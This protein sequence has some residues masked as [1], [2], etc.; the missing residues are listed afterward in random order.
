VT[1]AEALYDDEMLGAAKRGLYDWVI[2]KERI[3]PSGFSWR[4]LATVDVTM[5]VIGAIAIAQR[6]ISDWPAASVALAVA[7]TPWILFFGFNICKHE[8]PALWTAWMLG[9]A[10][11]LF[12]TS[13]P[14]TGD[15][16]PLLLSLTVGVVSAITSLRG[17][18]LATASASALLLLAAAMHR[19]DTAALY[20]AF[21]FIGWLVGYLLRLQQ[22]LLIKQRKAQGELAAHAAADE[23][24]RIAREVHDVI[25]HSLSITMLHLTGARHALQYDRDD[26]DAVDALLQA[27]RLG[28]QAMA[29]IRRTVGLLEAGDETLTPEPGAVDIPNLAEDFRRAGLSIAL[30]VSGDPDQVSATAGLA[31]YRIAQ[32]S[33][34]NI[35]K[36]APGSPS[37][38]ALM[39]SPT[40][41]TLTVANELRHEVI[42]E[43]VAPGRGLRGMRQRIELLGGTIDIGPCSGGWSVHANVPLSDHI[44]GCPARILKR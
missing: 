13:T 29:D 30:D 37:T 16:A 44:A 39:I 3:I 12:A 23:R 5:V 6:P 10:I 34:A 8:G 24:R 22:E 35:A 18:F 14:I 27:E 25:A 41:A 21:V 19:L 26:D 17:G 38:M 4:F 28:R 43:T 40:A 36:H 15:F 2:R 1:C 9:T 7:F 42:E 31:L 33:L 32:E 11:L 20:L